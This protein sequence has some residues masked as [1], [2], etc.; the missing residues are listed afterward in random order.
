MKEPI[1]LQFLYFQ[2]NQTSNLSIYPAV[3]STQTV[4]VIEIIFNVDIAFDLLRL[5]S[6]PVTL[7]SADSSRRIN[8]GYRMVL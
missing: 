4:I 6:Y 5:S 7:M 8:Q 1:G 2:S 3:R